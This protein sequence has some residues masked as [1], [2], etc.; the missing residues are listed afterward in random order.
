MART[1]TTKSRAATQ[2]K[3]DQV[4]GAVATLNPKN[5][6]DTIGETQ[7]QVQETLAGLSAKILEKLQLLRQV[8]D[9]IQLKNDQ[10]KEYHDIEAKVIELDELQAEIDAKY[11]EWEQEQARKKREFAEQQA[12]RN[13]AWKR[14]EEEYDYQK[15]M[16]RRQKEDEFSAI[17]GQKEKENRER[18]EQLE[19]NWKEREVDLA[20]REGELAELRE[21]VAGIPELIKKEVNAAVAI[22][23]NSVKK[24][25]ETKAQLAQKDAETAE[26]LA[27]QQIQALQSTIDRLNQQ[28]DGMR[29][30]LEQAHQRVSEISARA[31]DSAAGRST[32]EALQ[33][34]L[35][36]DQGQKSGK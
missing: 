13:R 33:R 8:E 36:K 9:S 28:V 4:L 22:A 5:V 31:V 12:E 35:E 23:T 7:V 29:Q 10:L 32:I 25:Y 3:E 6:S 24:E 20:R 1:K 26:K 17:L 21:K 14:E 16:E 27:S 19:K 2:A 15:R 34:A 11:E 18:Q 30:E